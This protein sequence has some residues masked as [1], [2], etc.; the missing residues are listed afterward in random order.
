MSLNASND[1]SVILFKLASSY[2][3]APV[4][5][6]AGERHGSEVL[7]EGGEG[8]RWAELGAEAVRSGEGRP[9]RERV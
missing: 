2:L 6:T 3:C 8:S 1:Q 4:D 5:Q 9:G 7:P